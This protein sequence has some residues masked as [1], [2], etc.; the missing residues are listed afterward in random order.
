[1]SNDEIILMLSRKIKTFQQVLT[2]D[3]IATVECKGCKK[4]VKNYEYT[5]G[6]IYAFHNIMMELQDEQSSQG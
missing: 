6:M 4:Q 3:G 2:D 5:K 1:M